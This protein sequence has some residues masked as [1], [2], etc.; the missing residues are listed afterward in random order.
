M[1]AVDVVPLRLHAVD[2]HDA[3][4]ARDERRDESAPE[5]SGRPGDED[6]GHGAGGCG[7]GGM[8]S[9][10]CARMERW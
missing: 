2:R 6:V 1:Y 3:V 7:A 8:P 4:A 9:D 5:P 10:C